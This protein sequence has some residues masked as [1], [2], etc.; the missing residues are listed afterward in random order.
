MCCKEIDAIVILPQPLGVIGGIAPF[1]FPAMIVLWMLPIAV[2]TG[3][4]FV[5]KPSEKVRAC[6]HVCV[7]ECVRAFLM[8][9]LSF[10]A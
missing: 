7:S 1:N 8:F 4:A 10:Y 3:N 2:G 5:L 6:V 9:I